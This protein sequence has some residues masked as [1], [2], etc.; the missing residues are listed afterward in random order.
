MFYSQSLEGGR[1]FPASLLRMALVYAVRF[2]VYG[3]L[4]QPV[5][6]ADIGNGEEG[7]I[8]RGKS[9]SEEIGKYVFGDVPGMTGGANHAA[10]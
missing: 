3:K 10:G 9:A 1:L 8:G 6:G 4:F 5:I 7:E 2:P